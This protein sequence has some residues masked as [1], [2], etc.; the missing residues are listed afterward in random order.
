MKK[1]TPDFEALKKLIGAVA[2]ALAIRRAERELLAQ[3]RD[4]IA[5]LPMCR[6]DLVNDV[7]GWID[8]CR[9]WYLRDL[10]TNLAPHSRRADRPLP[11]T[12][13]GDFGLMTALNTVGTTTGLSQFAVFSLLGDVIKPTISKAIFELPLE[14][15]DALPRKERIEIIVALDAQIAALDDEI[16]GLEQHAGA[17]GVVPQRKRLSAG[18]IEKMFENQRPT[19]P[20]ARALAIENEER[21]LNGEPR[22]QRTLPAAA[23]T[24][25]QDF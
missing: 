11:P 10:T 7:C 23:V 1:T 12:K 14:D 18:D 6:E 17:A 8:D 13:A 15:S 3:E 19:N 2:D 4:R 24:K 9:Q 25:V 20:D 5:A 21:L 22:I 16:S